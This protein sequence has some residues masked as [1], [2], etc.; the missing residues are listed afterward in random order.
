MK[1]FEPQPYDKVLP[2]PDFAR[3]EGFEEYIDQNGHWRPNPND[4]P[5]DVEDDT[6]IVGVIDTGIPLGH[7]RFRNPDGSTRVLAAW[8]QL[9]EWRSPTGL[10]QDF[11]PFGREL[12]QNS[13]NTLLAEHS[14]GDLEGWLDEDGFNTATG[15]LDMVHILGHREVAGRFSHGAH[16]LDAAA[17]HDPEKET[18]FLRRVKI[19]TVNIP[20]STTFG[21]SGTFLDD[22]MIYAIQRISDVADEIWLKNHPDWAS[23]PEAAEQAGYPVVTNISFGKQAGSKT[24]LDFFPAALKKFRE[25]RSEHNL[26]PVFFAMPAGNDNLLRGNAYLEPRAGETKTLD[27]RIL[28]EDQSS[29][30]VEIWTQNQ[31]F[32]DGLPLEIAVIPPGC[33]QAEFH[34]DG[35]QDQHVRRLGARGSI[36]FQTVQDPERSGEFKFRYVICI[37]PTSRPSG[38]GATAP[39][40]TWTIK[41]RNTSSMRIQCV[42]A[43]QTDQQI[44]PGRPVNL[45]SYFDDR[46]YRVYDDDGILVESYSYPAE[47]PVNL[48]LNTET[49]IRRHGT[50]NASAAHEF[51]TRVGG[52]RASDGKPAHYSATGRGRSNG[53]DD[54]TEIGSSKRGGRKGAPTASFPTDDGPAHFGILSAGAA[55]GSVA[56]MRGTSFASSQA[57]RRIAE[58]LLQYNDPTISEKERLFKIADS[59]EHN[60]RQARLNGTPPFHA[61]PLDIENAGAGRVKSPLRSRVSRT[62]RE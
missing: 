24:T 36:Y 56:A 33:D 31:D 40:G 53:L 48:D 55:N 1:P 23:D 38:G 11:L 50:M 42:L 15:V 21:A 28:P 35:G 19:I 2:I 26:A 7:N 34:T 59:A 46:E 29:N 39:A 43:V 60:D 41:V 61:S 16:V 25:E 8:Q 6:I 4:L 5:D 32:S 3:N 45:L 9:A 57:T 17:G 51:V 44:Q 22:F 62:G 10:S 18:D 13:I 30:Y 12:Y 49:P 14:G 58:S 27:W 47:D 37:A 20:S 54:G 52:Y